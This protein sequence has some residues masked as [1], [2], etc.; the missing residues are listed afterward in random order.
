MQICITDIWVTTFING[1]QSI[2]LFLSVS[3]ASC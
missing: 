1:I 3:W 2:A